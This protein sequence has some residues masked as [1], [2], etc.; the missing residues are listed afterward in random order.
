MTIHKIERDEQHNF[1]PT[2]KVTLVDRSIVI[3]DLV[4]GIPC[5]IDEQL[6]KVEELNEKYKQRVSLG[7]QINDIFLK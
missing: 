3:I 4:T 5:S 1:H 7:H 2:R 6:E